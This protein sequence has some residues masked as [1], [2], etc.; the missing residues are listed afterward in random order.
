MDRSIVLTTVN[1]VTPRVFVG[2][3]N[4]IMLSVNIGAA[5]TAPV[6]QLEGSEDGTNFY[7]IGSPLT[8]VASSTVY[9]IVNQSHTYARARVSTA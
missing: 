1:S 2:S 8:A 5:T 4:N 3:A 6:L 7:P 9:M